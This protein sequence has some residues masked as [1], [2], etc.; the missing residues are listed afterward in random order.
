MNY[1][2]ITTHRVRQLEG[3]KIKEGNV[4]GKCRNCFYMKPK[5]RKV[6]KML[7]RTVLLVICIL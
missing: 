6:I 5:N 4:F 3:N 7:L 2:N 1:T